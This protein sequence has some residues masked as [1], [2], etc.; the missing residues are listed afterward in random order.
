MKKLLVPALTLTAGFAGG[1]FL[2]KR[3]APGPVEAS[4]AAATSLMAPAPAAKGATPAAP[5]PD[6]SPKGKATA[7]GATL[8]EFRDLL[9]KEKNPARATVKMLAILDGMDI[10]SITALAGQASETSNGWF[11]AQTSSLLPVVYGKLAELDPTVALQTAMQS[12][13]MWG[14]LAAASVVVEQLAL[15]NPA[16]AAAAIESFPAGYLRRNLIA[17][18]AAAIARSD[19]PA[20]VAMLQHAKIPPNDWTWNQM[21]GTWA[22]RD[23]GGA[24][25]Q[26]LALPRQAALHNVDSLTAVWA[27]R[28]PSAAMTWSQSLT[29]PALRRSALGSTI[30]A[31]ARSDPR[32]AI[33]L[34]SAQP[35][36]DRRMLMTGIASSFAEADGPGAI[37]WAKTLTDPQERQRCLC[38]VVEGTGYADIDTARAAVELISPGA[39]RNDAL[40]GFGRRLGWTDPLAARDWAL[41]LKPNEQALVMRDVVARLAEVD[42]AAAEKLTDSLP[43]SGDNQWAWRSIAAGKALQDPAAAL[44]WAGKLDSEQARVAATNAVFGQWASHSPDKATASLAAISDANLRRQATER[45]AATWAERSPAEATKWAE[46]LS[47]EDRISALSAVWNSSAAEDPRAAGQS[48][49]AA[50]AAAGSAT[51]TDKLAAS[52][53]SIAAAWTGQSPTDAAAWAL[54]LPDGKIREEALGQV[55]GEWARYD[56]TA[57]SE[58]INGLPPDRS[59]DAAIGQLVNRIVRTDPE[60][61]FTW[62][63]SVGNAEKQAEALKSAALAWKAINPEAA[64]AAVQNAQLPEDIYNRLQEAIR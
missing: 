53:S 17:N 58:W 24:A 50:A 12:K 10:A 14:R 44:T 51:A 21:I 63:A 40:E 43:P 3:Q 8:D 1:W 28:D 6:K 33:S 5:A 39:Q 41:T 11:D 46:S 62:A 35:A 26:L 47:G 19:G 42:P 4:A 61:A 36:G 30:S 9:K 59:R 27:R 32:H 45:L 52:A 25:A 20:A 56:P 37:A 18:A 49:A 29:D 7:A 55:A 34:A 22:A 23:P 60:S 15:T 31:I 57:V 64:R 48:L 54:T 38:A 13:E 16:I 2:Q